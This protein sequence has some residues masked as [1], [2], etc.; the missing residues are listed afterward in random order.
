[1]A[2]IEL[3]EDEIRAIVDILRFSLTACPIE[4]VSRQEKITRNLIESIISKLEKV[5]ES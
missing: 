3:E 2:R 1:M 4:S 5:G